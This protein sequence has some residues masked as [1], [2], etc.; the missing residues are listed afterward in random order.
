MMSEHKNIYNMSDRE[1]RNYRRELRRRIAV[2]RRVVSVLA[3]ICL[4]AVCVISYNSLRSSASAGSDERFYK[5]YTGITVQ[6]NDTLWN[7]ADE[8]I[9]YELYDSKQEYIE[10]VC[11]INRLENGN[12]LVAG[13]KLIMPYYSAEYVK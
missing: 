3:T 11:S 5:Y 7:L 13:R 2:R 9:N 6:Y 10:E 1:L 12:A 8:Y 4:I